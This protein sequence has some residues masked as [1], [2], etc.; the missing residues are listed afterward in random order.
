M[1]AYPL[2]LHAHSLWDLGRLAV[3]RQRIGM[4][5]QSPPDDVPDPFRAELSGDW[6]TAAKLWQ[7]LGCPHE[8]ALALAGG[9]ESAQRSAL[10]ILDEL[11]ARPAAALLRNRLVKGGAR[12]V[13]RGPRSTTRSNPANLTKRQVDVLALVAR[14]LSNKEIGRRLFLS[15]RTVDH[16]VSALLQKLNATSRADAQR[17]ARELGIATE[18]SAH[19]EN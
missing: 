17:I 11:G 10:I 3:W 19:S 14:G 8:Q 18:R 7:K 16:H 12:G 13:P 4:L 15:T 6:R 5:E 9:D 1:R 2:A